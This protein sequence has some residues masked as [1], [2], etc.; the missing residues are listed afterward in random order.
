MNGGRWLAV[1]LLLVA[2]ASPAVEPA[3][4]LR[5]F[6]SGTVVLADPALR[7][8]RIRAWFADSRRHQARGL[9]YIERLEPFEGMLFRY[10]RPALITMWMKNTYVPLDML[11]FD[12]AGELERVAADTT[13][14]SE[15]RIVSGG[16]VTMVLELPAGFAATWGLGQGSRLLLAE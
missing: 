11:F 6:P 10:R 15:A 4:L 9:M 8:L 2:A 1:C 12:A 3:G 5:D 16:P 7:C 14:L 13:P